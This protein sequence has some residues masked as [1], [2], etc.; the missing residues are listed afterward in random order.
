MS[1]VEAPSDTDT[2]AMAL[3]PIKER[4]DRWAR[5]QEHPDL[6]G[7]ICA[8]VASGGTMVDLAETYDIPFG[9]IS[10]WVH[11]DKARND[12]YIAALNDRAEWGAEIVLRELRRLGRSDIRQLF[13]DSGALKPPGDWPEDL[14][15]AVAAID[16]YEECG[17]KG[18]L[19]GYTKKVKLWPKAESLK[20]LGQNLRLFT[21]RVEHSLSARL[22][23]L[24]A[25]AMSDEAKPEP[26]E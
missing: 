9:W 12:R 17:P 21:E 14:A 25:G 6:I 10:N 7:I 19:L 22:E 15:A 16:V 11:S 20:M 1:L 13:D 8:H 2:N 23:D 18:E 26:K 24:V 3:K 5:L 4:R